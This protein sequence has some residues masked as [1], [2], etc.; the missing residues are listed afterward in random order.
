MDSFDWFGPCSL[1]FIKDYDSTS[2]RNKIHLKGTPK[3]IEYLAKKNIVTI[4]KRPR[5]HNGDM[6]YNDS[7][8]KMSRIQLAIEQSEFDG[9]IEI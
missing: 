1:S 4:V 8:K 9:T 2:L 3:E 5:A 7:S 6:I